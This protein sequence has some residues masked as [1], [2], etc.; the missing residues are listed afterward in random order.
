M[1]A[2]PNSVNAVAFATVEPGVGTGGDNGVGFHSR[3]PV[4]I[5]RFDDTENVH[6]NDKLKQSDGD[7]IA[8]AQVANYPKWPQSPYVRYVSRPL[9]GG[10]LSSSLQ[11]F[12]PEDRSKMGTPLNPFW[13]RNDLWSM[14]NEADIFMDAGPNWVAPRMGGHTSQGAQIDRETYLDNEQQIQHSTESSSMGRETAAAPV[15]PIAGQVTSAAAGATVNAS[16]MSMENANPAKVNKDSEGKGPQEGD[17]DAKRK[18]S[19][20]PSKGED[21]DDKAT[22]VSSSTASMTKKTKKSKKS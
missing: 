18:R 19:D 2:V 21:G 22:P 10:A 3:Q 1:S 17:I 14:D 16:D 8:N 9:S 20:E 12:S 11:S 7:L 6:N 5:E 4:N 15:A 13:I